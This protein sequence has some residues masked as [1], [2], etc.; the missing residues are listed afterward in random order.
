MYHTIFKLEK[1]PE[2]K[3]IDLALKFK[4]K[5]KKYPYTTEDLVALLQPLGAIDVAPL[6]E[7]RKGHTLVVF[8]SVVDAVST[9]KINKYK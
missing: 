6:T 5:K 2:T 9:K 1:I 4:W 8:N 3:D 7:K